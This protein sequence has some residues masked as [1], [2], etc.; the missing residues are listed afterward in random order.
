[1]GIVVSTSFNATA[2]ATCRGAS[3]TPAVVPAVPVSCVLLF[4]VMERSVVMILRIHVYSGI[5]FPSAYLPVCLSFFLTA[6]FVLSKWNST[7]PPTSIILGPRFFRNESCAR[8]PNAS[9]EIEPDNGQHHGVRSTPYMISKVSSQLL[10]CGG[11]SGGAVWVR[12]YLF[13]PHL[14]TYTGLN[15]KLLAFRTNLR[16]AA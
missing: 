7:T 11:I 12:S 16:N 5:C 9:L 6:V 3:G 2:I 8:H 1:M 10:L 13:E 15:L 14:S 4:L